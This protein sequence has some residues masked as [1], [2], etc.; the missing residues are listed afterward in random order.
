M[1]PPV[2]PPEAHC[3]FCGK[4]LVMGEILYTT[5]ARVACV[6]CNAKVEAV[7]ADASVGHN[8]RNAS[9]FSLSSAVVGFVTLFFPFIV[10]ELVASVMS[11]SSIAAGV[12]AL[13]A[14]NQK[15]DERF[16]QHIARDKGVIYACSIIGIVIAA[17]LLVLVAVAGIA[18]M[19]RPPTPEYQYHGY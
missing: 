4:H 11:V 17:L 18:W 15:G 16:T 2:A 8:I 13:R 1:Q 5:D 12:Y 9:I 19:S 10:F 6:D 14:A 7:A 3:N